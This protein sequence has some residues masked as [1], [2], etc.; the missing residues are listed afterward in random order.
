MPTPHIS[1]LPGDFA[2]T[3]SFPLLEAAVGAA[4]SMGLEIP[5]GNLLSSDVF[6]D[7]SDSTMRWAEM[8]VLAVE[9]GAA[10]RIRDK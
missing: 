10:A 4:R 2:P 1:A 3:A 7:S 9:M 5:V 8:G 6:Y